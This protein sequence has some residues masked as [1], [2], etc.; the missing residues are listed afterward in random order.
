MGGS[1]HGRVCVRVCPSCPLFS[2]AETDAMLAAGRS[3]WRLSGP[4]P[5]LGPARW[6]LCQLRLTLQRGSLNFLICHFRELFAR[7]ET[8]TDNRGRTTHTPRCIPVLKRLSHRLRNDGPGLQAVQSEF[9]KLRT[10]MRGNSPARGLLRPFLGPSSVGQRS[11]NGGRK[12][13]PWSCG[14]TACCSWLWVPAAWLA[15][16]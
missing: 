13:K 12:S 9:W 3:A 5:K 8:S 6:E 10:K 15:P 16:V 7:R 4:R 2:T 1:V 11:R 14:Y